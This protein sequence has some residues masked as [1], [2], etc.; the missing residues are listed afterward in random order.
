M[1][2]TLDR[3]RQAVAELAATVLRRPEDQV[4]PGLLSAGLCSSELD[5]LS[6]MAVLSEVGRAAVRVPAL[7]TIALGVLPLAHSGIPV[8]DRVVLTAVPHETS[9]TLTGGVLT[10]HAVGVPYAATAHRILVPAGDTTVALVDPAAPGVTLRPSHTSTGA[11]EFSLHLERVRPDTVYQG[12]P[13]LGELALAGACAV[14]S[15]ALAGALDLTKRHVATRHQFGRPLAAFQAV[16]QQI[17]D[18]YIAWRTLHLATWSACWRLHEGLDASVQVAVAAHWL[19]EEL[20]PAVRTCH[21]LHGGLGLDVTYPL[22]RYYAL[23]KDL[24]RFVGGAAQRIDHLAEV[25]SCTSS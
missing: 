21:H 17:A 5:V 10:G 23:A 13:A 7:A 14:A 9:V 2:F 15:G 20:L 3:E 12:A 16:A 4:W 1:D 19:A 24:T 6:G 8:P 25:L 11:P 22:H 18:V